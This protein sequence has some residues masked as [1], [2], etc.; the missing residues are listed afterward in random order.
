M[1]SKKLMINQFTIR[2]VKRFNKQ[3]SE[4]TKFSRKWEEN[5]S[6]KCF[7]NWK[8]GEQNAPYIG[9]VY[10][11]FW[12]SK[13]INGIRKSTVNQKDTNYGISEQLPVEILKWRKYLLPKLRELKEKL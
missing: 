5:K 1:K 8:R 11:L 7:Q 10:K 6:K 13:V 4:W 12:G 9:E 3:I 2:N